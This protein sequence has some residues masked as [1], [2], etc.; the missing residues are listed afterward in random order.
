M[1]LALEQSGLHEVPVASRTALTAHPA[2]LRPRPRS[3]LQ[4]RSTSGARGVSSPDRPVKSRA[5]LP[6]VGLDLRV[7]ARHQPVLQPVA[8]PFEDATRVRS[9]KA[10]RGG[11]KAEP[12]VLAAPGLSTGARATSTTYES[13]R[14]EAEARLSGSPQSHGKQADAAARLRLVFFHS[15]TSGQCRRTE[16]H[17]AQTLQRRKNRS[18]F[19]VVRVDVREHPDLAKRFTVDAVPTLIVIEDRRIV[20]RIVSPDTALDLARSLKPWLR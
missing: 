11:P 10:S 1:P 9:G 19:E 20:G 18:R 13:S 4:R 7:R 8:A 3:P 5:S 16:A 6:C 14:M 17:L 12:H 15:P 2:Q